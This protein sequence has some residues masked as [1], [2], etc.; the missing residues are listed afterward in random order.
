MM[1]VLYVLE[2]LRTPFW[3]RFF[4]IVTYLGSELVFMVLAV[5]LYWCV[6]KSRGLY[7]MTVGYFGT[8]VSQILKLTFRIPRP[9]VRDPSFTIV[10]SARADAGGYSFP[11]GHTQN[12][13]GTFGSLAMDGKRRWVRGLLI[14]LALLTG[15]SR[16][17]LGV[18]TPWDVGAA[19]VLAVLLVLVL[20]PVFRDMDAHP[21]RFYPVLAAMLLCGALYIFYVKTWSFPP[22]LDQE[23]YAEGLANAYKLM[24]ALI[25]LAVGYAVDCKWIHFRTQAPPAGQICKCVLGLALILVLKEGLKALLGT[26]NLANLVRYGAVILFASAV[27]PLTFPFFE[28]F[29]KKQVKP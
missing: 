11:S 2:Q 23:N 3:D 8:V 7:V 6:S 24:G 15:F 12:A 10:E 20:H 18:H 21:R 9:W 29:G 5:A 22:D 13:V 1:K 27:W 17:Y 16:M 25:G 28:K 19:L 4:S 14:A 26:G